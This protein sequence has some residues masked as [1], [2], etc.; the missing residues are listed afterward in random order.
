MADIVRDWRTELVEAYPD[1]FHPPVG[2]PGAAQGSPECGEGWCDLL[3]R[4]FA[5]IRTAV[6]AD[7]GSLKVAQIKEK[8]GT[9]RLYW[10]GS[11]S[12]EARAQVAEAVD[13][14]EA[15]SACTCELC[16]ENGR[17]YGPDW[18]TTRC[19]THAR[20]RPV[21]R[22]PG[23]ENI[24]LMQRIVD[25]RLRTVACRRYDRASDRFIDV[26]P[27]SLGIEEE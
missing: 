4:A 15:R 8:Y 6:Q 12:P 21:E 25:G 9:L 1:L 11:L 2:D 14:A 16:G 22:P 20:G 26:D 18:L 19:M 27:A 24:H 7:G 13:L 3:E 10:Q 23:F 17:L 5:R